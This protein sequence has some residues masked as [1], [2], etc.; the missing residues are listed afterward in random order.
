MLQN[1][2][3]IKLKNGDWSNHPVPII[4]LTI[5]L[6]LEKISIPLLNLTKFDKNTAMGYFL[7]KRPIDVNIF[8]QDLSNNYEIIV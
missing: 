5:E 1:T 6:K 8:Q 3:M 2:I 4:F 7:F